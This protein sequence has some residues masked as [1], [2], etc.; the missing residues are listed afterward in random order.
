MSKPKSHHFV[1]QMLLRWFAAPE[2]PERIWQLRVD[3]KS[4]P[5]RRLISKT[6][7]V[8]HYYTHYRDRPRKEDNLFWEVV[9]SMKHTKANLN[10]KKHDPDN[11]YGPNGLFNG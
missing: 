7:V 9:L 2:D 11:L 8:T 3:D 5:I 4:E 1:P 6:A 10:D